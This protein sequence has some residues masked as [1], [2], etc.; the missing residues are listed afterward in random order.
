M[1]NF[2]TNLALIAALAIPTAS[3]AQESEG[4]RLANLA[5]ANVDAAERGYIDQGEFL[6]FGEDVFFSMDSNQDDSLSLGEFLNWGF[7]MSNLA[8]DMGRE[9]AHETALRVV[10]AFWDRDGDGIISKTEHRQSLNADFLR[11]DT[12]SNAIL[13]Q[14]EFTSGFSVMVALRAAINPVPVTE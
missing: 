13:S 12:N 7:G 6:D 9:A 8:E 11:A 3:A 5:F 4:Q 1:K 10:F 14:E 2:A